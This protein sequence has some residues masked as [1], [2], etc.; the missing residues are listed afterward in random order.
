MLTLGQASRRTGKSKTTISRAIAAG[1]LSAV[2]SNNGGWLIDPE[3][4]RLVYPLNGNATV[5]RPSPET[6]A[7]RERIAEQAETI[8]DLR[9]RLDASDA[10]VAQLLH[11]PWWKRWG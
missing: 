2:R 8:R 1:R 11:R 9:L 5:A 6:V 10:R 3:M 7:L 4:L